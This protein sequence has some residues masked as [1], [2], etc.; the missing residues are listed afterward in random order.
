MSTELLNNLPISIITVKRDYT[1]NYANAAAEAFLGG[2]LANLHGTKLTHFIVAE[3]HFVE[4]IENAF[5][6]EALIKE[7]DFTIAVA[8]KGK[9]HVNLQILPIENAEEIMIVIDDLG[10]ASKLTHHIFKREGARSAGNMASILAHEVKNPLSGIRGAAQLLQKTVSIEDQSLTKLICSEVDRIRDVMEEMEIFSNQTEIQA[11]P[12][13]IHEVLQYVRLISENGGAAH[14][15][16]KENYDPSLPE[17]L[18]NRNLLIQLFLNLFNNAA[19]ALGNHS[20]PVI[21]LTTSYQSGFRFKPENSTESRSL[22][23]IVSVEDNGGGISPE[24]RETIFDPFVTTKSG[25]KGLGLAI[26]AK[27]ISDHGGAIELDSGV[28]KGARFKI[29]LPAAIN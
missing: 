6:A 22:P 23:I 28:Q 1:I 19:E 18:G 24:L 13:N 10:M 26:V 14:V 9:R 27:I 12:I 7:Y 3:N 16:F 20:E 2:G 15:N 17:V 29:L 8:R 5:A 25:G 4:L 21:T 11:Q